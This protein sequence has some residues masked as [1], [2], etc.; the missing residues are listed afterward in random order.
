MSADAQADPSKHVYLQ[1][2]ESIPIDSI[3]NAGFW[4]KV[5]R[6]RQNRGH[7]DFGDKA[8]AR[9]RAKALEMLAE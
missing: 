5:C 2:N 8:I 9:Q 6:L 1:I 3:H 7:A 4:L